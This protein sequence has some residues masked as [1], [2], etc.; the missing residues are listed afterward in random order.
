MII[1]TIKRKPGRPPNGGKFGTS[2]KPIRV[3]LGMVAH[4]LEYIE[5][6]QCYQLPLYSCAVAAGFPS[7]ADDYIE[8]RLNLNELLIKH[9]AATFFLRV[10][11]DSMIG[12]GIYD[13]DI[14]IVDK[15]IPAS[16]GKIVIAAIDGELTVKRLMKEGTQYYLAAENLAYPPIKLNELS[17][18]LIWGVVMTVLHNV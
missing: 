7:P 10:R 15:S 16:V 5:D 9:P 12:A 14:L 11:G 4:I 13:G 3:P 17:D 8:A 6:R 1:T 18:T 2:T